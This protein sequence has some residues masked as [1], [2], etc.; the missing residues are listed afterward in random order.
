[1]SFTLGKNIVFIDSILLLNS[2][3]YKLVKTLSNEDFK[4]LS[5][6][7]S[8]EKLELVK[9]KEFILMSILIV[10]KDL[11]KVNYQ[12]LIVFLVH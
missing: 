6:E 3:L 12:T 9:K 10:L 5:R 1:M 2:S 4:Y 8:G 11:V 7:F